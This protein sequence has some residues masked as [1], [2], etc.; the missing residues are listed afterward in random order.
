MSL[1][2]LPAEFEQFVDRARAALSREITTAKNIIA[3]ATAEK[4]CS[5][6]RAR[7]TPKSVQADKKPT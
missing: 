3:A 5:A 7:R 2:G 4:K 1:H 6:D